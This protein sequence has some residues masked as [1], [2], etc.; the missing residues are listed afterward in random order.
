MSP[1]GR[2]QSGFTL[3]ELL[4]TLA[5]SGLLLA[6]VPPLIG[7]GGDRA[8]LNHDRSDLLSQLRLARSE[9]IAGDR[10]VAVK[11][12][13]AQRIYSVDGKKFSLDRGIEISLE[14]PA[15]ESGQI[16]FFADGSASGAIIRLAN[17][18]GKAAL[19]VDWLTGKVATAP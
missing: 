2:A 17:P 1:A 19:S 7:K 9:A 6:L 3:I 5:L 4:V 14:T 16:R 12:D 11:F 13:L 10:I 15:D 8:R 18:A